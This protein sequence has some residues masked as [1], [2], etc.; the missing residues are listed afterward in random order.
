MWKRAFDQKN[1]FDVTELDSRNFQC[2]F[3]EALFIRNQSED[4]RY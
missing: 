3:M 2:A 4:V 1:G